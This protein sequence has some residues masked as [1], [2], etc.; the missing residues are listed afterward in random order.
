M[1]TCICLLTLL[2][3]ITFVLCDIK[4]LVTAL[5]DIAGP[6]CMLLD[7][8]AGGQVEDR[9]PA[10]RSTKVCHVHDHATPFTV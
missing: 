9:E 8:L 6:L 10:N 3:I 4:L 2:L 5:A 1:P 7:Y